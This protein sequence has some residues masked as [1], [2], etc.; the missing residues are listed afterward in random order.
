LASFKFDKALPA[1]KLNFFSFYIIPFYPPKKDE[2]SSN[3]TEGA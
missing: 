2:G 3:E 1:P